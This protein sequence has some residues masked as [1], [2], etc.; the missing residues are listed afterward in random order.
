[1]I[2]LPCDPSVG[3]QNEDRITAHRQL[4]AA[5]Y[6]ASFMARPFSSSCFYGQ[7]SCTPSSTRSQ[8]ASG[9][10]SARPC[11]L[12]SFH[13]SIHSERL[14][15]YLEI[16]GTTPGQVLLVACGPR[17]VLDCQ[18]SWTRRPALSALCDQYPETIQHC[19]VDCPFS[20]QIWCEVLSRLGIMCK[21]LVIGGLQHC[22][23]LPRRRARGLDDPAHLMAALETANECTFDD[24]RPSCSNML[25]QNQRKLRFGRTLWLQA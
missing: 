11:Y 17:P 7:W 25:K 20:Q 8:I 9:I 21:R 10:Y 2:D 13:G 1:M 24:A 5:R 12:A 14:I 3:P 6:T 22:K 19:L 23:R 4:D 16:M 18:P 15:A